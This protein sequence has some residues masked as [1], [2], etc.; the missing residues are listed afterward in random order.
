LA[1]FDSGS[2]PQLGIICVVCEAEFWPHCR[3]CLVVL[4]AVWMMPAMLVVLITETLLE[5][6]FVT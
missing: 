5:D 6:W 2:W 3:G 4:C 1:P